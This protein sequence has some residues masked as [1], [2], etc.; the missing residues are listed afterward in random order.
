[1]TWFAAA[2]VVGA[3]TVGA[4]SQSHAAGTTSY[5]AGKYGFELDRQ[6]SG[7]IHS[8]EGGHATADVVTE[9]LG[10][11]NITKKSV[12]NIK[13]EPITLNFGTGM[14]KG[15]YEW[16]KAS[17]TK[18]VPKS[19]AVVVTNMQHKEIE[20]VAFNHALITEIGFPACD[21]SS[22]DA[23]KMTIKLLPEAT[24]LTADPAGK[25]FNAP[26]QLDA[27]NQKLWSPANFRIR[28]DG[29]DDLAMHDVN[30]VDAITLKQKD[31]VNPMTGELRNYEKLPPNW[32]SSK[33]VISLPENHAGAF[34]K[35]HDATVLS[36]AGTAT[37]RNG[38]LVYLAQDHKTELFTL[39]FSNV[40]LTKITNE[41]SSDQIRRVKVE[42]YCEAIS[43]DYSKAA[44]E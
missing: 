11:N 1:M 14:S 6:F 29:I 25:P 38:V 3:V 7:W 2:A 9:K 13:Y 21:A 4:M 39:R 24:K 26:A 19:G 10:S 34:M 44:S 36:G 32:E 12:T 18:P 8:A 41:K 33:I 30:K 23:A 22:K 42:M 27:T 16:I 17:I 31:V 35:W 15:F 28:I 43:F 20:R 40:G 5:A 37:P